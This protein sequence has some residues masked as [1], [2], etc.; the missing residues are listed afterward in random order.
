M[1]YTNEELLKPEEKKKMWYKL[2]EEFFTRQMYWMFQGDEIKKNMKNLIMKNNINEAKLLDKI[3]IDK[4]E[5]DPDF[6]MRYLNIFNNELHKIGIFDDIIDII[7]NDYNILYQY[8]NDKKYTRNMVKGRIKQSF[9]KLFNEISQENR[10]KLKD[11]ILEKMN[12]SLFFEYELNEM[13]EEIYNIM[14]IEELLSDKNIKNKDE[15]LEYAFESQR[16]NKL[17]IITFF[18]Q[19][20]IEE[21]GFLENLE[22]NYGVYLEIDDFVKEMKEKLK[23]IKSFKELYKY[24]GIEFAQDKDELQIIIEG[25]KRAK[26]KGYIR[27]KNNEKKRNNNY[28]NNNFGGGNNIKG[29]YQ[30]GNNYAQK[31]GY[32]NK[33]Y[34]YNQYYNQYHY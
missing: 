14:K 17:L 3:F 13:K 19:K 25:Y 15:I 27:G 21:K 12:F 23:E 9:K 31:R 11:I 26:E 16:G 24:I 1:F 34:N 32:Y 30:Y 2:F 10:D 4:F 20:K 8:Y 6:K 5:D 29:I 18:A 7:S 22:N 28:N 33:S